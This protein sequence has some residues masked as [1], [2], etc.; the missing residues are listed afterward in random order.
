MS[1]AFFPTTTSETEFQARLQEEEKRRKKEYDERTAATPAEEAARVAA[2]LGRRRSGT[3]PW[4]TAGSRDNPAGSAEVCRVGR[5][6]VLHVVGTSEMAEQLRLLLAAGDVPGWQL[7]PMLS[8]R[9]PLT[10]YL[11]E[12]AKIGTQHGYNPVDRRGFTYAEEVQA[13]PDSALLS[14]RTIGPKSLE[15]IR[16]VFGP[17]SGDAD[18]V[19]VD[20]AAADRRRH[21]YET[22]TATTAARYPD[23]LRRMSA[24][25]LPV[26]AI[27]AICASLNAEQPPPVDPIVRMLLETAGD[28]MML[29]L[30]LSTHDVGGHESCP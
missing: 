23:L 9:T 3:D 26:A 1:D 18:T 12:F 17:Y 11:A 21:I 28:Q 4:E 27:D 2:V 16:R 13:C 29:D 20:Q 19:A 7:Q 15:V 24:S 22:A 25:R 30:Y 14:V 10:A 5:L 8:T 6:T